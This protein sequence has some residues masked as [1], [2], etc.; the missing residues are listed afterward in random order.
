MTKELKENLTRY[1]IESLVNELD[2]NWVSK[3]RIKDIERFFKK[4]LGEGPYYSICYYNEAMEAI[5]VHGYFGKLAKNY[6][7]YGSN[8]SYT[9]YAAT[10]NIK[11]HE[12]PIIVQEIYPK[13]AY[14]FYNFDRYTVYYVNEKVLDQTE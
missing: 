7:C 5:S 13:T 8:S 1:K 6:K 12:F 11:G 2:A 14:E 4:H 9:L 10:G 3:T